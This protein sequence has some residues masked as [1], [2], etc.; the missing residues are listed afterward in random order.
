[1]LACIKRKTNTILKKRKMYFKK[2]QCWS[3]KTASNA[4]GSTFSR[5]G[6]VSHVL[7]HYDTIVRRFI[8]IR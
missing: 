5:L 3:T 4:H 6:L 7:V 8:S 2:L 1:M